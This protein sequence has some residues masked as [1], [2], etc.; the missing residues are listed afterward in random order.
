MSSFDA[1]LHAPHGF[2]RKYLNRDERQRFLASAQQLPGRQRLFAEL[3]AWTGAR[4]SEALALVP[5]S[6]D[7]DDGTVTLQTLKRRRPAVRV[8][9]LPPAVIRHLADVFDLRAA[10][11]DPDRAQSLLWPF[12]RVTG[13]RIIKRV[14]RDAGID[15]VQSSPRGLRHGFGVATLQSGV[16]I[17]LLKR[18]LGHA[19][20]STTEIYTGVVGQ[21]EKAF[22]G[23]FWSE[24]DKSAE[25]I[26]LVHHRRMR[27]E[28]PEHRTVDV[29]AQ[30]QTLID[31]LSVALSAVMRNVSPR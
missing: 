17:T 10:Q 12:C 6:F 4:I 28:N 20:L 18:W 23:R 9:P 29:I 16:P 3:L 8:I 27:R 21:E 14:M 30:L 22:A 31:N 5:A 2:G 26:D 19:R 25:V 13:W 7:L 24:Q 1:A 11:R 15:G